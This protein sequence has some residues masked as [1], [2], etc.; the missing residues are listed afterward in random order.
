MWR[1]SS[2]G[3]NLQNGYPYHDKYEYS[4]DIWMFHYQLDKAYPLN[5]HGY[6]GN[7]GHFETF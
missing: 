7:G 2:R 1:S 3:E 5:I 4:K 6:I